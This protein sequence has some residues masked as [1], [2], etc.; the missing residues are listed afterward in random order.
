MTGATLAAVLA[1]VWLLAVSGRSPHRALG[2]AAIAAT[3][4]I[5]YWS[6]LRHGFILDDF[7]FA[8][9]LTLRQLLSTLWGNWDPYGRGNAQYR[10]VLALVLALDYELWGPRTW[11]YHLTNLVILFVN[12]LLASELLRRLT[13]SARAGL[14]GALA[15]VAH[16]LS[17]SVAG[18]CAERTDSVMAAFYLAALLALTQVPWSRRA[19]LLTLTFG[20]LSLGSKEMAATLPVTAAAVVVLACTRDRRG[21]WI[22]VG[23][24][25]VL[26][27]LYIRWWIHLLPMKA[28]L[29]P[30]HLMQQPPRLLTPVFFPSSYEHWWHAGSASWLPFGALA[31]LLAGVWLVLRRDQDPRPA[32]LFAL[33]VLWPLLTIGPI[34]GLRPP[35]VYRLGFLIAFAFSLA[36]AVIVVVLERRHR[37]APAVLM[38][39][40]ALWFTPLARD[41]VAVWGPGGF[42]YSYLVGANLANPDWEAL[43]SPEM[44]RVFR[45]QVRQ[46]PP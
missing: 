40:L 15:W 16:P 9:P 35:D 14:A 24:L 1:V 29:R 36:L 11:G 31:F 4:G 26:T 38:G 43:L 33:A 20:A 39:A 13:G 2:A 45:R 22:A 44:R 6:T 18:W 32:R 34:F 3:I 23:G 12:G 19:F 27:A 42:Q 17:T 10:P 8:R 41:S 5:L 30:D 21:R 46:H 37:A 25:A 28:S 7:Y